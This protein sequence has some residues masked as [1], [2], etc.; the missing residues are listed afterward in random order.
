MSEE[1]IQAYLKQRQSRQCQDRYETTKKIKYQ[2]LILIGILSGL[3]LAI[4]FLF[5]L[6]SFFY[7]PLILSVGF[8][9]FWYYVSSEICK[10]SEA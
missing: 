10:K 2:K 7:I 1:E 4:V 3:L 8:L 6:P 5:V 9:I